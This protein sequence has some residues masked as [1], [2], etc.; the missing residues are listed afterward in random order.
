MSSASSEIKR[1]KIYT[2][3]GD[4]GYSSLY[5]GDRK[6]KSDAFFQSLGSIDELS[7]SMGIALEHCITDKNGLEEYLDKLIQ[8]MLDLGACIAT[9]EA[10][11][12]I[13]Q[14]KKTRFSEDHVK[15]LEN[16]IDLL[17]SKL[18]PLKS[19][20]IPSKVGL[21]SSHLHLSRAICRRAEREIVNL[22]NT[23]ELPVSVTQFINRLS[24]FLFVAARY[25]A[26]KAGKGEEKWQSGTTNLNI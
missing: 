22:G 17:D 25:A 3:T 21:S 6:V 20:I 7:A 10:T 24:D 12:K 19:F 18:P 13:E 5:N 9:P 4:K 14:V 1:S 16:W 8:L 15:N 23:V 11:S 26:M 2:K